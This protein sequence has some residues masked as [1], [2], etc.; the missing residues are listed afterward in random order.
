MNE[1]FYPIIMGL[2]MDYG[3]NDPDIKKVSMSYFHVKKNILDNLEQSKNNI[4]VFTNV[5]F[6]TFLEI[7]TNMKNSA[8]LKS[9]YNPDPFIE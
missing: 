7:N 5:G 8:F 3:C 9:I 2:C 4:V 1:R 6:H